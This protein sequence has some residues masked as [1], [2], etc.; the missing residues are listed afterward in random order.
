MEGWSQNSWFMLNWE[1]LL[2]ASI[3]SELF[4]SCLPCRLQADPSALHLLLKAWSS[5]TLGLLGIPQAVTS[6]SLRGTLPDVNKIVVH[7]TCCFE[8]QTVI[9]PMASPSQPPCSNLISGA[10]PCTPGL[11]FLARLCTSP[12]QTCI[13]L[14]GGQK[15][16]WCRNFLPASE[17]RNTIYTKLLLQ[18]V[19]PV[20]SA[21]FIPTSNLLAE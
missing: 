19:L 15:K 13:I 18:V 8:R 5:S 11:T 9:F 6:L 17:L 3:H 21:R 12:F 4:P 14:L 2:H 16:L 10:S 20:H 7:L 1:S